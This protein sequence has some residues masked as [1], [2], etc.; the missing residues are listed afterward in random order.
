MRHKSLKI[1]EDFFNLTTLI[2]GKLSRKLQFFRGLRFQRKT[3]L[4]LQ[5]FR[6]IAR[7]YSKCK[8]APLSKTKNSK[9]VAL[10]KILPIEINNSERKL[11][12]RRP[13]VSRGCSGTFTV[14]SH[15]TNTLTICVPN[16]IE[17]RISHTGC[18]NKWMK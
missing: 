3:D 18:P 1:S 11:E 15:I 12:R 17:S 8:T 4:S 7:L 13:L 5:N 9:V 10:S 6:N 14:C 16:K 2:Y